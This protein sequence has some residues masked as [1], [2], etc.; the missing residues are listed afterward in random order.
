MRRRTIVN[1]A[2]RSLAQV[3]FFSFMSPAVLE[4]MT[5]EQRCE[6]VNTIVK[7]QW[8][9]PRILDEIFMEMPYPNGI[10][11]E[12][13]YWDRFKRRNVWMVRRLWLAMIIQ[14]G[15]RRIHSRI[16]DYLFI[17]YIGILSIFL[18]CLTILIAYEIKSFLGINLM[19]D[20]HFFVVG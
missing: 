3:R 20:V 2:P 14:K 19:E 6:I 8:E 13:S 18:V 10:R 1:R 17:T 7:L 11:G 9:N 12:G 16:I 15:E 5:P 4:R